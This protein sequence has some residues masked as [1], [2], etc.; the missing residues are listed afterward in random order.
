MLYDLVNWADTKWGR[1]AICLFAFFI[2]VPAVIVSL[3][4]GTIGLLVSGIASFV[5][6]VISFFRDDVTYTIRKLF[7]TLRT[8]EPI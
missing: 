5:Q 8:G 4:I 2:L 6:D 7:H 1:R 3:A